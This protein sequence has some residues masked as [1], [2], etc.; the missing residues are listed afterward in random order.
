[1][2]ASKII[3]KALISGLAQHKVPPIEN[4]SSREDS[5]QTR[6]TQ[7]TSLALLREIGELTVQVPY[8]KGAAGVLLRVIMISDTLNVNQAQLDEMNHN[9]LELAQFLH[10]ATTYAKDHS[11]TVSPDL[12]HTLELWP[13]ELESIENALVQY[14]NQKKKKFPLHLLDG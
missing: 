10:E 12:Q 7:I 14:N 1:M 4:Q 13:Q 9:I 8:M 3:V 2:Q 11:W 5:L 6:A